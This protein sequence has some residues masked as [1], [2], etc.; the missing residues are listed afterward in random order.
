MF[1]KILA[2]L[3]EWFANLNNVLTAV[4]AAVAAIAAIAGIRADAG[5]QQKEAEASTPATSC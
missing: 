2:N 5:K 1:G 3:T 4:C